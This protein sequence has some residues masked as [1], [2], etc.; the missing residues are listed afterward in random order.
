M[1]FRID[2]LP[3]LS[4]VFRLIDK[5]VIGRD[6]C[7]LAAAP[8]DAGVVVCRIGSL[9]YLGSAILSVVQAMC[10]SGHTLLVIENHL[11][12]RLA[13]TRFQQRPLIT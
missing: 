4:A 3:G 1:R 13:R 11:V 5:T 10:S 12:Q 2:Y 6:V 9:L 7:L 8:K